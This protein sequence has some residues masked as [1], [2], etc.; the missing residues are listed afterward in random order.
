MFYL[1]WAMMLTHYVSFVQ[2]SSENASKQEVSSH[3]WYCIVIF[4]LLFFL[5][6]FLFARAHS[7]V[8]F[9]F[10]WPNIFNN[11]IRTFSLNKYLL[12]RKITE[13]DF[14]SLLHGTNDFQL[15][16]YILII[17]CCVCW[18]HWSYMIY[19]AYWIESCWKCCVWLDQLAH[20]Q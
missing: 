17:C 13:R 10:I 19:I 12:L 6:V 2:I 14:F 3:F 4:S 8:L 5:F 16:Y 11:L 18:M 7:H 9:S 1:A 20:R 15:L